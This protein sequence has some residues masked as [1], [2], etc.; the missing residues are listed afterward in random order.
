MTSASSRNMHRAR[1]QTLNDSN[2]LMITSP[3]STPHIQIRKGSTGKS[4]ENKK[5][6]HELRR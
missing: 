6:D 5:V 2:K 3:S 1:A 4:Y